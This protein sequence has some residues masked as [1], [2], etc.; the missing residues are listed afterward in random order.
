MRENQPYS[1]NKKLGH[2]RFAI[3][4][5][6]NVY[7]IYI[8]AIGMPVSILQGYGYTQTVNFWIL[9]ILFVSIE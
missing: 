8:Q 7:I 9:N 3:V 5:D 6:E 4:D 1:L 2:I